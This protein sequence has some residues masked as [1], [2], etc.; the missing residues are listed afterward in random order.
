MAYCNQCGEKIQK[1]ATFCDHCGA[2]L[3][4]EESESPRLYGKPPPLPNAESSP[5]PAPSEPEEKSYPAGHVPNHLV[6]AIIATLCC[7]M[8][9]G[10]AGIVYAA[11][12]DGHLRSGDLAAAQE[13]SKKANFWSNLA[14]AGGFIVSIF[15]FLAAL[16]DQ[17][18]GGF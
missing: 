14:I 13:S 12:V 8:P 10:V 18:A 7:C 4:D 3:V 5:E 15:Y 9:A 2:S 11:Q 17:G 16:A 6:K 1:G